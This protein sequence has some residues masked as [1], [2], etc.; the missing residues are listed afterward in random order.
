[1]DESAARRRV[2]PGARHGHGL[3]PAAFVLPPVRTNKLDALMRE[4]DATRNG[5][6]HATLTQRAFATLR[7]DMERYGNSL[8]EAHAAAL[9]EIVASYTRFAQGTLRGRFAY[10]LDT[11]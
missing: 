4:W 1:M 9:M 8:S 2:A 10:P 6:S 5:V 11:G 3:P 7:A